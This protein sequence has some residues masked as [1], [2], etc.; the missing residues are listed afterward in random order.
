MD[1]CALKLLS[2]L[3]RLSPVVL[4][5][6]LWTA[7]GDQ[8][9]PVATPLTPPPPD[10]RA[11]HFVF[12]ID[13][14]GFA[15]NSNGTINPG[16]STRID[17]SGDSNIG[18]A[19][20]GLGPVHA[21]LQP[22][23]ARIYVANSLEDSVS[24]YAP[25]NATAVTT[26]SLVAG[27]KPVFVETTESGAIY[28]AN[29]GNKSV[30]AISTA[31]NVVSNTMTVGIHP[32]ALSETPN[33]QKVYVAN[34]GDNGTNGSVS[35]I[36]TVDK[37]VNLTIAGTSWLSPRS[38]AVRSDGQRAYALDAGNGTIT[39]I[40]TSTDTVTGIVPPSGT[41]AGADFLRY[42]GK[43]NRLY[44]I[45]STDATLSI[46]DASADPPVPLTAAALT[47][48][49]ALPASGQTDP[50]S[51]AP[52]KPVSIAALPDGTRAYVGSYRFVPSSGALCSQISVVNTSSNTIIAAIPLGSTTVDLANPNPTGCNTAASI[53]AIPPFARFSVSLAA[54]ADS[55]RVYAANCDAGNT[56]ILRTLD[57][58]L[59][60]NLPSPVS[61]FKTAN[62]S[63][64]PP[65]NP[66]FILAGP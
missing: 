21:A 9:R 19:Q 47:I 33:G 34:Q 56:A 55:S 45:S 62:G 66:V 20:V 64:P 4:L 28:V 42:D 63:I 65:Q 48:S 11:T 35:S 1:W 13:G 8:F 7:C 29:F 14:N 58:V 25:S 23:G 27:S 37:S 2:R 32:V 39:A 17:V 31:S 41:G 43:L 24:S 59:V 49:A 26:T 50:C 61:D 52:V 18:V 36:N 54:S 12:V 46:L 53:L 44:V 51:G 38:V 22:S 5:I 57:N 15:T 6:F 16:S 10:P 3:V 60:L 40:D 30:S